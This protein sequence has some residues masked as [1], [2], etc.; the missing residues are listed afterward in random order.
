MY[1]DAYPDAIPEDRIETALT[2]TVR[3]HRNQPSWGLA[4]CAT[5]AVQNV[6]CP[7]VTGAACTTEP[8]LGVIQEAVIDEVL[9]QAGI[10]LGSGEPR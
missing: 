8:G 4:R 3:L 6:F 2:L 9:R 10:R 5:W 7:C 1:S